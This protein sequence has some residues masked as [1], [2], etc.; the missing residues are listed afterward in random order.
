VLGQLSTYLASWVAT[1][2]PGI[3]YTTHPLGQPIRVVGLPEIPNIYFAYSLDYSKV[4]DILWMCFAAFS[5]RFFVL[6]KTVM[7]VGVICDIYAKN[8]LKNGWVTAW[9]T[10]EE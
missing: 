8:E 6:W 7:R 9:R 3:Y 10:R 4:D 1:L 2:F 5:L